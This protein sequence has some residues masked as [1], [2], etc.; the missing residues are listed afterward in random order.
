MKTCVVSECDKPSRAKKMCVK[1]YSAFIKNN[2]SK[3]P[4]SIEGCERPCRGKQEL[5]D[6]HYQRKMDGKDL[7]VPLREQKGWYR[8]STGYIVVPAPAW[9]GRKPG[10]SVMQHV[11][12]MAE[13]IGRP[14]EPFETVHHK[15]GV[16]DDNR[17]ENLQLWSGQHPAG[18]R[19][20]DQIKW[21]KE[22]IER[23]GVDE[24]RFE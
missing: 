20:A 11:L 9:Y 8:H 13:H 4:C 18:A 23:Y 22:I 21:A 16:R 1:H 2:S 19:V 17:L 5:C 12:V 6:A 3:P 14:L 24:K 10:A 15:N 7:N